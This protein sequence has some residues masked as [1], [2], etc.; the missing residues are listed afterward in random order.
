MTASAAPPE[1]LWRG[2]PVAPPDAWPAARVFD[3]SPLCRQADFETPWF[4]WWTESLGERLRYHRKLWEFVFVA[5][6]L[7][8]RGLLRM[9]ARGLGF[10][11]GQEPLPA[12]FAAR[13]CRI[14]ATDLDPDEAARI[15]WTDT[16]QHAADLAPLQ[17]PDLCPPDVLI[18]RVAFRTAD[19]TAIPSDLTGFDFCWSACALEHLGSIAAGLDFIEASLA[20]L[21]PG[22]V[23]VH[24]TEFNL[25]SDEDTV[26]HQGTVLFRARD[27][28]ALAERLTA[29]GHRVAP[30]DLTP[31]DAPLDRFVDLPPYGDEPHLRLAL[32]GFET[33]SV[34]IIVTRGA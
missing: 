34:G 4:P 16:A 27:L 6:A 8:E 19:M 31:G 32:E 28:R 7:H 9:G 22:G 10:G 3:R 30:L 21:R 17:R 11:V 23:A 12:C 26:D 5:Q 18:E 2:K 24:T 1:A 13:G 33:T 29:Q 20:T 25:T 15:G 14:V